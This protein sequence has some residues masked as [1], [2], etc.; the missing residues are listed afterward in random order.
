MTREIYDVFLSHSHMDA[1]VVWMK[2]GGVAVVI[3]PI[4]VRSLG[5]LLAFVVLAVIVAVF[6]LKKVAGIHRL[7]ETLIRCLA[8]VLIGPF[9]A[10]ASL[11]HLQV[12]DR[13]FLRD[14]SLESFNK[15][16]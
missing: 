5:M 6:L 11:F 9:G 14:G 12:F 8:Y 7:T 1:A 2:W 10:L 3:P 15:K 16:T 13:M 4:S